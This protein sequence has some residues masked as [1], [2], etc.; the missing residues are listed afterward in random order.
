M[1]ISFRRF[2]LQRLERRAPNALR[3]VQPTALPAALPALPVALPTT[4]NP[5]DTALD[6]A[7]HTAP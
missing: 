5:A 1:D 4:F 7:A 2:Y 6:D 3:N